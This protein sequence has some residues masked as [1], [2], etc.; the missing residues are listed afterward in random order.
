MAPFIPA[1]LT[2]RPPTALPLRPLMPPPAEKTSRFISSTKTLLWSVSAQ[3][4]WVSLSTFSRCPDCASPSSSPP[5]ICSPT[6][7]SHLPA[8]II[9]GADPRQSAK[10]KTFPHFLI[11][12][13]HRPHWYL[14]CVLPSPR[15]N[16]LSPSPVLR[17]RHSF[18]LSTSGRRRREHLETRAA[19]SRPVQTPHR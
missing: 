17:V 7:G 16:L 3:P 12:A 13:S 4:P 6:S 2:I 18:V 10:P 1:N 8:Q 19:R 5:P 15:D 14:S 9:R 11:L